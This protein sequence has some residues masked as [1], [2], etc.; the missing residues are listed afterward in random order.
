MIKKAAILTAGVLLL[1]AL[2]F[3]SRLVPYA[4]TAYEKVHTAVNGTI[5]IEFQLDAAKKLLTRIDGE[6]REMV[7]KIA[8]EQVAIAN[9]ERQLTG[10]EL[11]LDRQYTHIMKLRNHLDSGETH[12]VVSNR[13]FSNHSVKEDLSNRFAN[14]KVADATVKKTG[15]ILDSRRQSLDST[16]AKLDQMIADQ[17]TLTLEVENL[18]A[19]KNM[20]DIAKAAQ[21]IRVDDSQLSAAREMINDIKIRMDVEEEVLAL[22]PAYMGS[23]PMDGQVLSNGGNIVDDIDSYFTEENGNVVIK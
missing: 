23:I 14:Y 20:L 5:P 4:Q 11:E 19:R 9:L 16:K 17:Q 12:F 6:K 2:M 13:R 7:Y 22:T 1:L 15:Q 8:K 21:N 10:Q 18:R 3:G